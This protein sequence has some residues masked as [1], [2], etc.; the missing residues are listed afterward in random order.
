[1]KRIVLVLLVSCGGA[2]EETVAR[3]EPQPQPLPKHVEIMDAATEAP[4]ACFEPRGATAADFV[5]ARKL[6]DAKKWSEAAAMFRSIAFG[7]SLDPEG[8]YA[9]QLYVDALYELSREGRKICFDDMERDLPRLRDLYC[10]M[11]RATHEHDCE[12]LDHLQIDL[13]R[14]RAEAFAAKD[15]YGRA[16]SKYVELVKGWCLPPAQSS[17]SPLRCDEIVFNAAVSFL[18]TGDEAGAKRMRAIMADPKNKMST[19]PLLE[20]LDCRI[21]PTSRPQCH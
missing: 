10:A 8:I 1:L 3:T 21:D 2:R 17:S 16:A 6:F 19:S 15:E 14:L 18:A 11:Q 20:K 9:T 5:A 12:M 7:A 13:G 4:V